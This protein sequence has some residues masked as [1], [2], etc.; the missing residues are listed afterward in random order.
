MRIEVDGG[1][2]NPTVFEEELIKNLY[3]LK[4]KFYNDYKTYKTKDSK[5]KIKIEYNNIMK[6]LEQLL[7][8]K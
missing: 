6:E 5:I 1:I 3:E 8:K 4:D 2:I 7:K